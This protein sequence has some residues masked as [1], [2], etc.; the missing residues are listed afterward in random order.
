MKRQLEALPT[1]RDQ[2]QVGG[3]AEEAKPV[4]GVPALPDRCVGLDPQLLRAFV[5]LQH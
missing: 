2:Q 4:A 5:G 1:V 3:D